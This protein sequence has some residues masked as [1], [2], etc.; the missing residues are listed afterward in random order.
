MVKNLEQLSTKEADDI[1][2]EIPFSKWK[3]K[4]SEKCGTHDTIYSASVLRKMI[5]LN[6][7]IWYRYCEGYTTCSDGI[8]Y[9]YDET[10][11]QHFSI[12]CFGSEI[13]FTSNGEARAKFNILE[14]EYLRLEKVKE[15]R[16]ELAVKRLEERKKNLTR[17]IIAKLRCN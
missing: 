2:R 1:F 17:T 9:H 7:E 12:G 8:D 15:Q 11:S 6:L 14:N 13:Y 5:P 4:K 10:E 3:R 16:R